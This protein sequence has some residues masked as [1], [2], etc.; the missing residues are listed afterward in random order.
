VSAEV[1]HSAL[2]VNGDILSGLLN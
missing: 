1:Q 2:K